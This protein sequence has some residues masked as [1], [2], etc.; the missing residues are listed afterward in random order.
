MHLQVVS[1]H[2]EQLC[3]VSLACNCL[4][5]QVYSITSCM[6][7]KQGLGQRH[8]HI[9]SSIA[10]SAQTPPRVFWDPAALKHTAFVWEQLAAKSFG[11]TLAHT[12]TCGQAL[13]DTH[14][15]FSIQAEL[16][17]SLLSANNWMHKLFGGGRFHSVPS[18]RA[19][20]PLLK[21][22]GNHLNNDISMLAPWPGYTGAFCHMRGPWECV[23]ALNRLGLLCSQLCCRKRRM[24]TLH[25]VTVSLPP[26]SLSSMTSTQPVPFTVVVPWLPSSS[27]SLKHCRYVVWWIGPLYLSGLGWVWD[28]CLFSVSS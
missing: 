24:Q 20:G 14:T 26:S 22:Y 10:L 17:Q 8:M 12:S 19:S 9:I 6:Y 4:H 1:A 27:W 2:T 15:Q 3:R 11:R 23:L 5:T 7:I 28:C 18:I 16:K 21:L 25:P 13:T